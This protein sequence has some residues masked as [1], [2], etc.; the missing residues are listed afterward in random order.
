[1]S[2]GPIRR[3]VNV[4][5]GKKTYGYNQNAYDHKKSA[6]KYISNIAAASQSALNA[7]KTIR[8]AEN[9]PSLFL[10]GVMPRSGTVYA[11][12]VINQHPDI[13]GY[14]NDLWEVPFLKTTGHLLNAQDYFSYSYKKNKERMGQNDL[15]PLFGAAILS[16]LRSF[17]EKDKSILVKEPSVDFLP[18]F[19]IVFPYE[20]LI[21]INRDGRDVV[22]ST[23]KTWPRMDFKHTCVRWKNSADLI[24]N[25]INDGNRDN[26]LFYKF[27]KVVQDPCQF[28]K[29]TCETFNLDE[30]KYPYEN[31]EKLSVQ[32]S[33]AMAVNK[34]VSWDGVEKPKDFNP[35]GRWEDWT[36]KQKDIFKKIAGE[37]LIKFGYEKDNNW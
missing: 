3:L 28:A 26:Y 33:S 18:Y 16:Y 9:K 27:E 31:I 14:P 20:K 7:S 8:G 24:L 23:I 32:G 5:T 15:L 6:F 1:L 17:T 4:I 25:Y 30:S 35:V 10:H 19:D 21:I 37:T 34:K 2:F 36:K 12:K 22:R 11:A 29:D 13:Q